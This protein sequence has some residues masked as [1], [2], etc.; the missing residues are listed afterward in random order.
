MIDASG[1]DQPVPFKVTYSQRL[2][3]EITSVAGKAL[4]DNGGFSFVFLTCFFLLNQG[5]HVSS[6]FGSE[7]LE[8]RCPVLITTSYVAHNGCSLLSH[9]A[10]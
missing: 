8:D 10:S 2:R 4:E 5:L 6:L 9:W 1:T 3:D 7:L